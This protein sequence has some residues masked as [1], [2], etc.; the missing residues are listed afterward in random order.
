VSRSSIG[1]LSFE[2]TVVKYHEINL[3]PVVYHAD[4]LRIEL[5]IGKS[6]GVFQC[7]TTY[8]IVAL[9]RQRRQRVTSLLSERPRRLTRRSERCWL[10][11]GESQRR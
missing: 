3:K 2:W 9:P 11:S 8:S 10:A 1:I 6:S 4:P 5:R 7:I